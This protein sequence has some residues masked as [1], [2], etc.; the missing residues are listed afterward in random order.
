MSKT[1]KVGGME[2]VLPDDSPLEAGAG[3]A[4]SAELQAD[5]PDKPEELKEG[6]YVYR[7]NDPFQGPID[8]VVALGNVQDTKPWVKKAFVIMFL[9]LPA[10]I[11]E[12]TAINALIFEP[13]GEKFG[14]FATYNMIGLIACAPYLLVWIGTSLAKKRKAK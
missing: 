12:I 7:P 13:P 5:K 9:I 14:K 4:P 8:R 10:S 2:I 1:I 11:M 6:P 3:D